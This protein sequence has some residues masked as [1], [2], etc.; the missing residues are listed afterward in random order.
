M[1]ELTMTTPL[2]AWADRFA[3]HAPAVL[4]AETPCAQVSVRT[5]DAEAISRLGL[6]GV[7]RITRDRR[8]S[9]TAVWLGPDEWL[10]TSTH[11]TS[12]EWLAEV[13]RRA[14]ASCYVA[15]VSGQRTRVELGGAHAR[16]ILAHGCSIDLS[17][18][19]FAPDEV[20]QTLIAQTG[21]ILHRSEDHERF[22]LYVRSSFAEHLAAWLVDAAHEYVHPLPTPGS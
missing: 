9:E 4:L 8:G 18:R 5:D 22:V 16:T 3:S 14:G 2:T 17:P 10:L 11:R 15:D 21:V 1:D 7:C 12:S 19:S 6:P 20:A 13:E